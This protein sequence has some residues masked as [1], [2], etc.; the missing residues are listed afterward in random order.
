MTK[1]SEVV[2]IRPHILTALRPQ[3]PPFSTL[4]PSP[5]AAHITSSHFLPL[6]PFPTTLC[7]VALGYLGGRSDCMRGRER[8]VRC[9]R[10]SNLPRNTGANASKGGVSGSFSAGRPTYGG[11]SR[12]VFVSG[13]PPSKAPRFFGMIEINKIVRMFALRSNDKMWTFCLS[14]RPSRRCCQLKL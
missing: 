4:P 2:I 14:V 10:S 5:P 8:S 12:G 13:Y 11:E 7:V 6:P 1:Y 3:S 9:R